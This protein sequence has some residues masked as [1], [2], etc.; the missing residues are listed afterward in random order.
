MSK[1]FK[2][3]ILSVLVISS[4]RSTTIDTEGLFE[5]KSPSIVLVEVVSYD[6]KESIGTGFV[7]KGGY[8]VTNHHVIEGAKHV[9]IKTQNGE[10]YTI[11]GLLADDKYR[12]IAILRPGLESFATLE[13]GDSGKIH[14]GTSVAVIG[15]PEGF[16]NTITEGLISG[17][18][19]LDN[20]NQIFQFSAPIS[21]GSSGSPVFNSN[22]E[23]IAMVS[24]FYKDGQLINF[25]IPS[26]Q[27]ADLLKISSF[28]ST[29]KKSFIDPKM[30][31]ELL[32]GAKQKDLKCQYAIGLIYAKDKEYQIAAQWFAMAAKKEYYPAEEM[33]GFLYMKG[34][35]VTK[36]NEK[37]MYWFDRS[38]KHGNTNL[39]KQLIK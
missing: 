11:K 13:M 36:D 30:G 16:E 23:I 2:I 22:N 7:I 1:Y 35:G 19:N 29:N 3:I 18:R 31:I 25:A 17:I 24:S 5:K 27:I 38:I 20:Y 14:P 32:E 4:V 37:S 8:I 15:N 28:E 12:D 33:L 9:F 39:A 26:N 21:K 10:K 6:G 34:K